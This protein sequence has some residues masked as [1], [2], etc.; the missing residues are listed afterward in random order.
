MVGIS[1]DVGATAAAGHQ[2]NEIAS[3]KQVILLITI[4]Q[5]PDAHPVW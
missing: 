4:C 2:N 5:P 3:H 1:E